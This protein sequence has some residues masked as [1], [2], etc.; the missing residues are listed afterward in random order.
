MPPRRS[1][2]TGP[3]PRKPR[4][5]SAASP[6]SPPSPTPPPPHSP[7][8]LIP[9]TAQAHISLNPPS[10][11]ASSSTPL[12]PST[13]PLTAVS[14]HQ[15]PPLPALPSTKKR[16]R[17]R[18]KSSPPPPS[19]PAIDDT[20]EPGS[21]SP[22]P[23]HTS[24][25]GG[26]KPRSR[27]AKPAPPP[28]HPPFDTK[29]EG[30]EEDGEEGGEEEEG[31][32]GEEEGGEEEAPTSAAPKR[33]RPH[34][35]GLKAAK[36]RKVQADADE[37]GRTYPDPDDV[38]ENPALLPC[39]LPSVLPSP[40]LFAHVLH[41][42]S[43]F[44]LSQVSLMNHLQT[45]AATL[46]WV[47]KR[48]YQFK[49]LG[50]VKGMRE[51]MSDR[52]RLVVSDCYTGLRTRWAKE[53]AGE[54]KASQGKDGKEEK[55]E[56]S[57]GPWL[58][59]TWL[60]AALQEL[61]PGVESD[62]FVSFLHHQLSVERKQAV[63]DAI[64]PWL[65]QRGRELKEERRAAGLAAAKAAL[66]EVEALVPPPVE[67]EE[68]KAV[69]TA[70]PA[71]RP[72][73]RARA[74]ISYVEM[75]VSDDEAM[76][77]AQANGEDDSPE[78]V[79][80]AEGSDASSANES[81]AS[82]SESQPGK[83]VNERKRV[84]DAALVEELQTAIV[85]AHPS[86]FSHSSWLIADL[87]LHPFEPEVYT[88]PDYTA[89]AFHAGT[90]P[91]TLSPFTSA[92]V[93]SSSYL[94]AGGPLTALAYAPVGSPTHSPTSEPHFL[95]TTHSHSIHL[96]P[97][98]WRGRGV[99]ALWRVDG[100][101]PRLVMA[102][103]HDMGDVL[104]MEWFPGGVWEPKGNESV[105]GGG[106]R[107]LGVLALACSGGSVEVVMVPHPREEWEEA[108]AVELDALPHISL[109]LPPLSRE[110]QLPPPVPTAV[111]FSPHPS[112]PYLA[113]GASNGSL[114][115]Y[116]LR[117]VVAA[118]G[119]AAPQPSF[120]LL[121]RL[122]HQPLRSLRWSPVN[123]YQVMMGTSDGYVL[124]YDL[125]Q[126][127]FPLYHL[128]IST[129]GPITSLHWPRCRPDL[130][131]AAAGPT[132]RS[133]SLL[134]QVE[135][136][137]IL[138]GLQHLPLS[139]T[140]VCWGMGVVEDGGNETLMVVSAWSDGGLY[141]VSHGWR[142]MERMGRG[143]SAGLS[144]TRWTGKGGKGRVKRE[145]E[146]EGEGGPGRGLEVVDGCP[147]GW[148]GDRRGT[149]HQ[150]RLK[151]RPHRPSGRRAEEVGVD[152]RVA[153]MA[154]AVDP[155]VVFPRRIASGGLMGVLRLQSVTNL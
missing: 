119:G 44:H 112:P 124:I 34:K 16:G 46:S 94:H 113:V 102:I 118:A 10:S 120:H 71:R 66:K 96:S 52:D 18:K 126:P 27:A 2:R 150:E 83:N 65:L 99:V 17:G 45:S 55:E 132:I 97:H 87:P 24:P 43:A 128:S 79:Q 74:H 136:S 114:L 111:A 73:R 11:A 139:A 37:G 41:H 101:T 35:G 4:K 89:I 31:G 110:L 23:S 93:D 58:D 7:S 146:G 85:P 106:K 84:G 107:R 141:G 50:I 51:W 80:S 33:G 64:A 123:A 12:L 81:D 47:L 63:E 105:V 76:D 3:A 1:K 122:G 137:L 140:A 9:L 21:Q 86:P 69:S 68:V 53:H 130:Y 36:K 48:R 100:D 77:A 19:N 108:Q 103:Q 5:T 154:V 78:A 149:L 28:P 145:G 32:K 104:A 95:T 91:L 82:S 62:E 22:H 70:V 88:H 133:H 20:D 29:E 72:T 129:D 39:Y 143:R 61:A 153:L 98:R 57:T 152:D 38:D 151:M 144:V 147:M 67:E 26:R 30:E 15:S 142:D 155:S 109:P 8:P 40:A 14:D 90:S 75:M 42:L 49:A 92:S 135:R 127:Q 115:V 59:P 125:R 148:G 60:R 56:D 138:R 121:P 117:S 25:T 13:A 54:G 134:H 131:L 116:S 6:P